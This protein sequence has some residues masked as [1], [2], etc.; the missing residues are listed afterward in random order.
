MRIGMRHQLVRPLGRAVKAERMV[1][2]LRG[3]E[4][5]LG[6]GAVDRGGRCVDEMPARLVAA[7]FEH[8]EEAGDI[9][10]DIGVRIDQRMPHSRLRGEM[11]HLRK[12]PGGEQRGHFR[13]IGDVEPL[14]AEAR[15]GGELFQPRLLEPHVVV[16]IEIVD[17]DDGSAAFEQTTR[18]VKADEARG[19][20]DQD[21]F[22]VRHS[23][24]PRR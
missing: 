5:R 8:V 7:A 14:E 10:L 6:I 12:P 20:G 13:P 17:A 21:R 23:A 9:R 3:A 22:R 16:R 4:R 15:E 2:G 19:P 18:H 24:G 1:G 11:H